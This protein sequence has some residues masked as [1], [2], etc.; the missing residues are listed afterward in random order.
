MLRLPIFSARLF[1]RMI[2]M[3]QLTNQLIS[4]SDKPIKSVNE[5]PCI[6]LNLIIGLPLSGNISTNNPIARNPANIHK[7]LFIKA[8]ET[9]YNKTNVSEI[10]ISKSGWMLTKNDSNYL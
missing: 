3:M 7:V 4:I 1:H 10:R 5:G 8:N 2:I 9:R 6:L